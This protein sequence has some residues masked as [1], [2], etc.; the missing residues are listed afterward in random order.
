MFTA[1]METTAEGLH[2]STLSMSR[3]LAQWFRWSGFIS[4]LF[5]D[6]ALIK[7]IRTVGQKVAAGNVNLIDLA[8]SIT[9]VTGEIDP[10]LTV[11]DSLQASK[12]DIREMRSMVIGMLNDKRS[13]NVPVR[14]NSEL[15]RLADLFAESLVLTNA[16]QWAL[17]EHDADYAKRHDGFA[18]DSAQGVADLLDR[19]S[20]GA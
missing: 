13:A 10:E 19:I 16:L 3:S 7:H 11:R 17:A 20:A 5:L 4:A 1:T 8:I 12:D 2:A 18:A 6:Q 9:K 15:Q 14:V